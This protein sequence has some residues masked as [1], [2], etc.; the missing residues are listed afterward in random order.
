MCCHKKNSKKIDNIAIGIFSLM[1]IIVSS[2]GIMS[3]SIKYLGN[4]IYIHFAYGQASQI[5][6]NSNNNNTSKNSLDVQNIPA[7]KVHVGD[8]DIAY[9]VFGKGDPILLISG[10]SADMNAWEPSTL[11]E[12]SS[13]HTVIVFDNRGVGNS[14]TDVKPFSIQQLANDTAGL[15]D[16]LKIQKADVLGYSLGGHIAQQLT[17]TYQEKVNRLILIS[18]TCGGRDSIPKPP[19]FIKLQYEIVNKSQNN[20]SISQEEIKS[21]ISASLGSGWM[22]LHAE[23]REYSGGPTSVC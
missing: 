13:N 19:G 8:I 16:A 11:R 6:S 4:I 23:T 14:T 1:L 3:N 2:V 10:A 22:R 5:N 21:L 12:L 7:K 9:K 17:V 20:I 15:L 18:S